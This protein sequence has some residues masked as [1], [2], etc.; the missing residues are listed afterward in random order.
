MKYTIGLYGCDDSTIFDMELTETEKALLDRVAELAE[1]TH[2]YG[3]MPT[4]MIKPAKNDPVVS[5]EEARSG[6]GGTRAC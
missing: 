4:M 1:K 2:M 3:C 6:E 5:E